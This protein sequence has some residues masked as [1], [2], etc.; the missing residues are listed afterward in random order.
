M[1]IALIIHSHTNMRLKH[2]ILLFKLFNNILC[3]IHFFS[4]FLYYLLWFIVLVLIWL[5]IHFAVLY[6]ILVFI[7]FFLSYLFFEVIYFLLLTKKDVLVS[8]VLLFSFV[9]HVTYYAF[10]FMCKFDCIFVCVTSKCPWLKAL[11]FKL[12]CSNWFVPKSIFAKHYFV[13][14][15]PILISWKILIFHFMMIL[16]LLLMIV[17][18][19]RLLIVL[20]LFSIKPRRLINSMIMVV[21]VCVVVLAFTF[22][23]DLI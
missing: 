20:L 1:T 8:V 6:H 10:L 18:I 5:P 17:F 9:H 13:R 11:S 4:K 21:C 12:L 3:F 19:I 23:I 22:F 2:L 15:V 14:I 7:V 16:S